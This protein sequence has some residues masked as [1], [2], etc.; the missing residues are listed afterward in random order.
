MDTKERFLRLVNKIPGGCWEWKGELTQN[1]YGKFHLNGKK[2]RAHRVSYVIHLGEIYGGM[3]V[4]HKCDNRKCVNPDHLFL[5]THMDN[6]Q[7]AL[8]KGRFKPN[9]NPNNNYQSQYREVI[10]NTGRIFKSVSEF[11]KVNGITYGNISG[12]LKKGFKRKYGQARYLINK[13]PG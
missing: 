4:C 2:V 11:K 9:P 6:S 12:Q 8:K 3:L 10:D 5:G 13:N 1:G 7:D